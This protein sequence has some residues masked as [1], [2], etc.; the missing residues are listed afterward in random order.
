MNGVVT[1]HAKRDLMKI[2]KNIDRGQTARTAQSDH[3][4]PFSLLADFPCIK[5]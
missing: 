4:R 1:H 5:R 3:G 2:V